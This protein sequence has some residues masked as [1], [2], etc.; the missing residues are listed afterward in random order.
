MHRPFEALTALLV[1]HPTAS[2]SCR[3]IKIVIGTTPSNANAA[4]M[5]TIA[6]EFVVILFCE[7][8]ILLN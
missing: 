5:A 1:L 2:A 8:V 7:L 4:I 6:I 3:I